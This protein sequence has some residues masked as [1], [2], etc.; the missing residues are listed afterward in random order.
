LELSHEYDRRGV[1]L[2]ASSRAAQLTVRIEATL[3]Q[4]DRH[5]AQLLV[6]ELVT[7]LGDVAHAAE[8]DSPRRVIALNYLVGGQAEQARRFLQDAWIALR[9]THPP[10]T[11]RLVFLQILLAEAQRRCGQPTT[12]L[13]TLCPGLTAAAGRAQFRMSFTG[14]LE[15]ALIAADL[16]DNVA[17]RQLATRWDML[18][19]RLRLP[20]PVGFAEVATHTL[21][22][23]PALSVG[24]SARW[25]PDAL[26]A[27]VASAAEWC[28]KQLPATP[29]P[30][31]TM[32]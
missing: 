23:S 14:V 2:G 24:R 3:G 32:R 31:R 10:L 1:D 26:H 15:A 4:G 7:L 6:D 8:Q 27:S 9:S 29:Q 12:A 25:N 22:L 11:T 30:R 18:R 21:G 13:R 16:G 20:L 28:A 17:S 19:R 5:A